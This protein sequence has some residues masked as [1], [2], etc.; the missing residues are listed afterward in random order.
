LATSMLLQAI[1]VAIVLFVFFPRFMGPLWNLG[2][3][4]ESATTGL[5]DS[6]TPGSI[7]NL[8]QSKA[9]A[10]R[11]E[12]DGEPPPNRMLYWRGPVLSKTDGR[13]WT[14][15][16]A[17]LNSTVANKQSPTYTAVGKAIDYQITLEPSN[18]KWLYALDL[19]RIAPANSRISTEFQILSN[20]AIEEREEHKQYNSHR[21]GLQ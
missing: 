6:I 2:L 13:S 8:V 5:S 3:D 20:K 1:P 15:I 12:F 17:N 9:V 19:P 10:F 4:K 7:S 18:N 11:V 16:T 14:R 21:N